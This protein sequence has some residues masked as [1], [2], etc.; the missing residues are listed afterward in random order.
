MPYACV[1]GQVK[2]VILTYLAMQA[3]AYIYFAGYS[4]TA[5]LPFEVF[6]GEPCMSLKSS[7][8]VMGLIGC[9]CTFALPIA[10]PV[11]PLYTIPLPDTPGPG[12]SASSDGKY[13]TAGQFTIDLV[14]RKVRPEMGNEYAQSVIVDE[15]LY[16][17]V[18]STSTV[19]IIDLTTGK[20]LKQIVLP[21]KVEPEI[22][23]QLIIKGE[24]G[25]VYI[26]AND[27]G[28]ELA[29]SVVYRLDSTTN[30]LIDSG[31]P[32]QQPQFALKEWFKTVSLKPLAGYFSTLAAASGGNSTNLILMGSFTYQHGYEDTNYGVDYVSVIPIRA[33]D[34]S[35]GVIS[36]HTLDQSSAKNDGVPSFHNWL[37]GYASACD[38]KLHML[39]QDVS[40]TANNAPSFNTLTS[41]NLEDF[42]ISS[43]QTT[44]T[45]N[46]QPEQWSAAWSPDCR[47][48]YLFNYDTRGLV[49]GQPSSILQY[50]SA[51][52]TFSD[53]KITGATYQ[54]KGDH[55]TGYQSGAVAPCKE[56]LCLITVY[57]SRDVYNDKKDYVNLEVYKVPWE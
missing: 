37:S 6:T 30:S 57:N 52:H 47:Y 23:R 51:T 13:A 34:R 32:V 4:F 40:T 29:S 44:R 21:G 43:H 10:P 53:R 39:T 42:S 50:D 38:N 22:Y 54:P 7:L 49:G 19:D 24:D 15:T 11:S 33:K 12:V 8:T 2:S 20:K 25:I 28:G 14:N 36:H 1:A 48:A 18:P 27:G 55:G 41:V 45:D 31:Y 46:T 56:G 9:S 16:L 3:H 17:L 35:M 26:L 5:T